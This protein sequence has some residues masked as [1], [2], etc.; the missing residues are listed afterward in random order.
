MEK[1]SSKKLKKNGKE[2]KKTLRIKS[3]TSTEQHHKE[4]K[5]RKL[6]KNGKETQKNSI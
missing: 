5:I 3:F 2:R 1:K 6:K 4:K